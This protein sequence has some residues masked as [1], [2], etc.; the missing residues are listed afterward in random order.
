MLTFEQIKAMEAA[1]GP[2]KAKPFVE[3][4]QSSDQRVMAALLA[5]VATKADVA[6]FK[7]DIARLEGKIDKIEM[8]IR[9][10]IGLAAVA[11]AFFSPVAEK[12]FSLL[13]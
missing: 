4:F 2:D 13:K 8:Q 12:L 11:L 5:E 3:A 6:A 10:L 9:I 7:A 1:L